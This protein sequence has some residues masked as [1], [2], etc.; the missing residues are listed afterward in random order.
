MEGERV[1]LWRTNE[2]GRCEDLMEEEKNII[3]N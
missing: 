2:G 1:E 3:N